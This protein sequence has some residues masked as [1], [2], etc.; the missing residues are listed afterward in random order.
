MQETFDTNGH[1]FDTM[2]TGELKGRLIVNYL[3]LLWLE[4]KA[5]Q[6][7]CLFV[8]QA[9]SPASM[10]ISPRNLLIPTQL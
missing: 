3:R 5:A 6:S 7:P 2:V 4:S 8:Q 10:A 9:P 1:S